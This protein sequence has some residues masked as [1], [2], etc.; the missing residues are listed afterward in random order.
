ML[1][2]KDSKTFVRLFMDYDMEVMLCMI[3]QGYGEGSYKMSLNATVNQL[4]G[5]Y[6]NLDRIISGEQEGLEEYGNL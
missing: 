4:N 3:A 5:L 1:K 2:V 6:K